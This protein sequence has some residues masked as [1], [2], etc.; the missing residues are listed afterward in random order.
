MMI[1]H[2]E[3]ATGFAIAAHLPDGFVSVGMDVRGPS[4]PAT[5]VG[6]TVH[7]TA[8]LAKIDA[9][10]G[11]GLGRQPQD[12][13]RHALPQHPQHG[14][15]REAIRRQAAQ[16]EPGLIKRTQDWQASRGEARR[17]E[18]CLALAPDVLALP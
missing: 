1:P 6:R 17:S 15:V 12:R 10:R 14:G 8:R 2:M 5:P 13:R 16:H 4:P 11:R 7:A 18:A 9:I 3:M